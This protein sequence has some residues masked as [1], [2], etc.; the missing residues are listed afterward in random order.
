M[1]TPSIILVIATIVQTL[2]FAHGSTIELSSTPPEDASDP[3]PE[4]FVSYS[5]EFS[6]FPDFAGNNSSPNTF[7]N[8]LLNN[9]GN[10]T[11]TKPYIRVGGNTQDYA[12]YNASL[13]FSINSTIIPSR[14]TDY[15]TIIFIGPSYFES[16]NTWPDTKFSHGF[17]LGLGGNNS[18]GW[19]TLL[20]TVPLACKALGGGKLLWWE[21]GNEPDLFSTSAQGPVRPPGWNESTYVSQWLNGTRAIKQEL[22][23]SCPELTSNESYG[24]LAPSFA[25]VSNHLKPVTTWQDGLNV[26]RDIKLISS[27]NYIGGATQPGVTLQSTLMNHTKT[28][29]SVSAQAALAQNLSSYDIPFI[30]GETNSLYNEGAP[31][32]SNAFGAALWGI[33]FNLYCASVGIRRVHMHQGTNYRYQFWQPVETNITTKGTKAP[34]YGH[35]VV[36]A[37]LGGSDTQI[38]GLDLEDEREAAY[39][40]YVEGVLERVVV[41][42]LREYNY[43]VNGTSGVVNPEPRGSQNY[44]FSV[45][46]G[47][48]GSVGVQRLWANGSDAISGISWDGWSY[49]YELDEGRPVRLGNVT[50][51]E[52]V[53]VENGGFTV[54]VED[55]TAVV[56]NFSEGEG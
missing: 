43:T 29:S 35:V 14:A 7:S 6:S 42:N 10:F 37:M 25:G 48:S 8:N 46:D 33:D 3:I 54:A 21:Y 5:I 38:V 30:L 24:Y 20:D 16:Y 13:P 39:A 41:V 26:D 18:E 47:Y 36:A 27:H 31:G 50:V 44:T 17:N 23:K 1:K 2:G 55:S 51:G 53:D 15:P 4:A 32:L 52:V 12:L 9:L 19:Q 45:P 56:L 49:N 40:A 11:G 28:T 34:Y 22:Q